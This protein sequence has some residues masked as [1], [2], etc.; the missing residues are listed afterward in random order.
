VCALG[1]QIATYHLDNLGQLAQATEFD[2]DGFELWVTGIN[3]PWNGGKLPSFGGRNFVGGKFLWGNGEGSAA[4]VRA[5][6]LQRIAPIQTANAQRQANAAGLVQVD[7]GTQDG[8]ALCRRIGAAV[9]A[10]ELSITN[11]FIYVFLDV[12]PGLLS[13]DYW[14]AWAHCVATFEVPG[15]HGPI[16]PFLPAICCDFVEDAA[17][18]AYSLSPDVK[19]CLDAAQLGTH[20][21]ARCYGFWAKAASA[22]NLVQPLDWT[23]FPVYQQ[24]MTATGGQPVWVLLWRYA[25]QTDPP[26][27]A[28]GGG[29]VV[30]VD[31]TNEPDP[32][33]PVVFQRMLHI[34]GWTIATA[35]GVANGVDRGQALT[36]QAVCLGDPATAIDVNRAVVHPGDL[37]EWIGRIHFVMRYYKPAG[38][39]MRLSVAEL[40]ALNGAGL[41]VGVVWEVY[42]DFPHLSAANLGF[43]EA[44]TAFTYAARTI[45]QPPHTPVYFAFELDTGAPKDPADPRVRPAVETYFRDVVRGYEQYL[46]D[47]GPNSVPYSIGAYGNAQVLNFLYV[48]GL[49][50]YYWQAADPNFQNVDPWLH[51]SLWQVTG[52]QPLATCAIDA[53]HGVDFDRSWVDEGGFTK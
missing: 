20:L 22:A 23:R 11:S 39:L 48:Q 33:K 4:Q 9:G 12:A 8:A 15:P 36:N 52:P 1:I 21:Q 3:P 26:D 46:V 49:V 19:T 38:N 10:Q 18:H 31:A 47:T 2:W 25:Q 53:A 6:T 13:P 30:S 51:S 16:Q 43:T 41:R 50:S 45:N 28:F 17:T 29:N 7:Y 35:T 32:N 44:R 40:A 24:P 34:E 42:A 27:P 37:H 14:S 5:P